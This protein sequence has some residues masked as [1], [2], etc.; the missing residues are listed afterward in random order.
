M[1]HVRLFWISVLLALPGLTLACGE[2]GAETPSVTCANFN[3]QNVDFLQCSFD[4]A[5]EVCTFYIRFS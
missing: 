2:G 3:Q 4:E 1:V 5:T